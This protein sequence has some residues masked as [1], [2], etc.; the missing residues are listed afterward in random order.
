MNGNRF[1]LA[2]ILATLLVPEVAGL[3]SLD[4]PWLAIGHTLEWIF[5]LV[6]YLFVASL[7]DTNKKK[8]DL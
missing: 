2:A 1:L 8:D 7:Y 5:T 3:H 4:Q 6:L